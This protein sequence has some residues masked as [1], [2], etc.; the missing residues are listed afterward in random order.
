MLTTKESRQNANFE[1][2]DF[3]TEVYEFKMKDL[4][5]LRKSADF[6]L[7]LPRHF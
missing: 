7:D 5:D 4:G 2:S 3:C 1:Q 6:Q